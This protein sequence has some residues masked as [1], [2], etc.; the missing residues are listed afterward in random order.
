MSAAGPRPTRRAPRDERGTIS[1]YILGLAVIAMVLIAGTVAV[2]SAHLS[3]MRMLD[4][5]DGAAL[6]AANALDDAAYQQGVGDV[7]PLSDASVR[8]RAAQYVES[9]ERP[10]SILG[11]RLAPGTG[12]PDG[13]TAVVALTGRA[14]LPMIGP[15]LADLGVSIRITVVSSARSDV[16]TP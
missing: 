3:R 9:V 14:A 2:T 13:R 16:V 15:A 6:A 1:L 10:D 5:A 4:V 7:V 8:Q 11:W 12:S